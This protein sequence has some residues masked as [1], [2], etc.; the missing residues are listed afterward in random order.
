MVADCAVNIQTISVF[1]LLLVHQAFTVQVEVLDINDIQPYF[2]PPEVTLSFSEAAPVGTGRTLPLALD[3]DSPAN[4]V[5]WCVRDFSRMC[6]SQNIHNAVYTIRVVSFLF[7]TSLFF[8]LYEWCRLLAMTFARCFCV[9]FVF[10]KSPKRRHCNV[11]TRPR[12][13]LFQFKC[14]SVNL[15]LSELFEPHPRGPQFLYGHSC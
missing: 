15:N 5:K 2:D 4:G 11:T 3:S 7:L 9:N 10:A 14:G 12:P 8:V 1:L 13:V 6:T